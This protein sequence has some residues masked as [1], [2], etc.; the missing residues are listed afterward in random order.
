MPFAT[1]WEF[2]IFLFLKFS[3]GISYI[4]ATVTI[5]IIMYI[6]FCW[7]NRI[8]FNKKSCNEILYVFTATFNIVLLL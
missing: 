2:L 8:W 3:Y 4:F 5:I 6:T 7:I 1:K